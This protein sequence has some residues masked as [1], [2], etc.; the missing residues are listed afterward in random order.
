MTRVTPLLVPQF[1]I[2]TGGNDK[3]QMFTYETSGLYYMEGDSE[4]CSIVLFLWTAIMSPGLFLWRGWLLPILESKPIFSMIW[5]AE[6]GGNSNKQVPN[7]GLIYFHFHF[8]HKQ[9]KNVPKLARTAG[10]GMRAMWIWASPANHPCYLTQPP[11]WTQPRLSYPQTWE[12][13]MLIFICHWD[14]VIGCYIV[15][16][17]PCKQQCEFLN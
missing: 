16:G 7:V 5:L 14:F 3:G 10:M 1:P 8:C 12:K 15:D 9:E 4:F 11:N 17:H 6:G 13:W 2:P